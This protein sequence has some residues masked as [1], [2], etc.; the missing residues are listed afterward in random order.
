MLHLF[1]I[2]GPDYFCRLHFHLCDLL[3]TITAKVHDNYF[4]F[5]CL[6]LPDP[7]KLD[8][9]SLDRK[10]RFPGPSGAWQLIFLLI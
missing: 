9:F 5:I 8:N 3:Q 10:M 7:N 6:L 2:S 4:L 1:V